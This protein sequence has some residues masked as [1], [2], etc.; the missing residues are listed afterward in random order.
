MWLERAFPV[1]RG[2]DTRPGEMPTVAVWNHTWLP[3]SETFV[4]DHVESLGRWQ[5]IAIGWHRSSGSIFHKPA[6]TLY[7]E[8]FVGKVL[9][10][11]SGRLMARFLFRAV[12]KNRSVKLI[13]AH[14]GGGGIDALPIAR[15]NSIPLVVTFHGKDVTARHHKPRVQ[16]KYLRRLSEVFEYSTTLIAVSEFI[17]SK[18]IELGAPSSKVVVRYL[19]I[20]IVD[21][22]PADGNRQGILFVGRLVEKKGVEDLIRA[23]ALLPGQLRSTP[24]KIVGFG[25]ELDALKF[26]AVSLG[27]NAQFLGLRT[28][29]GVRTAMSESRIF[30]APSKTA[31]NGDSEGFGLVFLEAAAQGLPIVSYDHGGVREA[32]EA[33]GNGLLSPEGDVLTLSMN[34]QRLL[35]DDCLWQAFSRRGRNRVEEDFNIDRLSP[36]L[37]AVYD[38]VSAK[39]RRTA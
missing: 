5:P 37:E 10:K 15:A 27:V 30:V 13:H 36:G 14:F 31:P 18:L 12:I 33:N 2:E 9:R 34:I 25:P 38:E 11:L 32:V 22:E 29:A 35:E 20:P 24:L 16:A 4:R 7:S 19:G 21:A 1:A 17:A 23:V 39:L 8:A 3:A 6:V 26:L 28:S